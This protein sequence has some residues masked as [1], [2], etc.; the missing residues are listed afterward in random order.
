MILD[1]N[2]IVSENSVLSFG[3]LVFFPEG[4]GD[5]MSARKARALYE[6]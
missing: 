3:G 5:L 1:L 2:F 6:G 4:S